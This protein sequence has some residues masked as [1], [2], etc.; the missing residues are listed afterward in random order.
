MKAEA[1]FRWS[2]LGLVASAMLGMLL[3]LAIHWPADSV[4]VEQGRAIYLCGLALTAGLLA[5][6]AVP[7][8]D[9]WGVDAA[10]WGLALWMVI[11]TWC[12]AEGSNLR[13]ATN[14]LWV[15][16][17][18]AAGL[19]AARRC[20]LS[21]RARRGVVLLVIVSAGLLSVHGWH[22]LLV[23][24]PVDRARYEA[25]PEQVLAE[26]GVDAP[27]GSSRRMIFE[28]RLRDGGPSDLCVDQFTGRAVG[29]G[30]SVGRWPVG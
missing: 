21:E 27:P 22:Q 18:A 19:T 13:M 14:E 17:S 15:W 5:W 10:A 2:T 9:A 3:A 6:L 11:S 26:A 29:A 12:N 28:N 25:N 4:E 16:L 23:S 30:V 8:L 1:S 20:L 24:F 7:K